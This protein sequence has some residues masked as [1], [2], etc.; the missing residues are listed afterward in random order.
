MNLADAT[1]AVVATAAAELR[2]SSYAAD[3]ALIAARL[4]GP[5]RVAVVGRVKAGKST[6]LN[7]L[8][9]DRLAATDAGECTRVITEYQHAISYDVRGR[10]PDG[11]WVDV[12]ARRDEQGL[13][14]SLPE[15]LKGVVRRSLGFDCGA[16][17]LFVEQHDDDGVAL[18]SSAAN[19]AQQGETGAAAGL[20]AQQH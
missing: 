11:T 9:R 13:Q 4:D 15:G 16:A 6:L 1:R 5:L 17:I 3:I 10:L 12:P 14:I 20:G 19:F 2:E 18:C 7:A 8:V